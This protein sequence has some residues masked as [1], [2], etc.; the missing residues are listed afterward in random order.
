MELESTAEPTDREERFRRLYAAEVD[1]MLGFALRRVE[2]AEDAGDV[3]AETF[4]V[5]WRRF[6]ELPSDAESRLW[7]YGVARRLLANLRRGE[8]RRTAL[9]GR[10]RQELATVF[11]DIS[12]AVVE[13]QVIAAALDRLADR[14]REVL[15]LAAWEELTPTEIAQVLGVSAVAVRTRLS[16]SRARLR[17][18]VAERDRTRTALLDP[19]E[20]TR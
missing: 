4:L 19:H 8:L 17:A 9:G 20:E 6:D 18:L 16:R 5:A 2:R 13:R 15:Q 11:P 3:V 12:H 10:L 7:L 14:D 1:A